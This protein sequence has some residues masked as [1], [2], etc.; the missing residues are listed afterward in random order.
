MVELHDDAM[1]VCFA[2]TDRYAY[3]VRMRCKICS[4]EHRTA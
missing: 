1:A 2:S 4:D 3:V